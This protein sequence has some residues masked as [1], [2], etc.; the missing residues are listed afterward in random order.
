MP[1]VSERG[2]TVRL[3]GGLGNQLFQYATGRALAMQHGVPLW[4][5]HSALDRHVAGETPRT[6]ELDMF[7]IRAEAAPSTFMAHI[8]SSPSLLGR[9]TQAF[10]QDRIVRE[11]GKRFQPSLL[12]HKP[13]VLL[14]GYWQCERYFEGIAAELRQELIPLAEP[15]PQNIRLAELMCQA[16]CASIHVRRGDYVSDPSANRFHGTCSPSYYT[17]AAQLLSDQH[18]VDRFFL[19]SDDLSWCRTNLTLPGEV[20]PVHH[21]QRQQSYWDLWLMRQCHHHIIANSSFSWWGAWLN[22]RPDK[23]VIAPKRWFADHTIVH[24]II[25]STWVVC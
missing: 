12:R 10:A 14:I 5:D 22:E 1:A 11:L 15:A 4:L 25:P 13:P 18:R 20:I 21:N 6:F 8:R 7:A 19:F 23:V 3:A 24:D 2:V 9:L 17:Q 16:P